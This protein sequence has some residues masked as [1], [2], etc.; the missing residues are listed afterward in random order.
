MDFSHRCISPHF[1]CWEGTQNQVFCVQFE[2]QPWG[3]MHNETQ[4]WLVDAFLRSFSYLPNRS[5]KDFVPLQQ[6]WTPIIVVHIPSHFLYSKA[7]PNLAFYHVHFMRVGFS[8]NDTMWTIRG[9]KM[10]SEVPHI[11]LIHLRK[12][13]KHFSSN[14]CLWLQHGIP[15]PVM[16][17][18]TTPNL[19]LVFCVQFESPPQKKWLVIWIM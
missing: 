3:E 8:R 17:G 16:I 1:P 18:Y 14:G 2:S 11:F 10:L 9:S 19:L 6:Q 4:K 7:T 13:M 12:V 5:Q 15:F